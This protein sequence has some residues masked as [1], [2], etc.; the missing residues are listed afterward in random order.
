LK[1]T[2]IEEEKNPKETNALSII[3]P[4]LWLVQ[5]IPGKITNIIIYNDRW[6]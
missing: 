2:S 3:K 1:T 5:F 6:F 4:V